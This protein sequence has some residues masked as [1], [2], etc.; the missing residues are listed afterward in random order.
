MWPIG[1]GLV[2]TIT[3]PSCWGTHFLYLS[4]PKSGNL[5]PIIPWIFSYSDLVP[6]HVTWI[7]RFLPE[8][9]SS[10]PGWLVGTTGTPKSAKK[11]VIFKGDKKLTKYCSNQSINWPWRAH[12][13]AHRHRYHFGNL[14]P[15]NC[16]W[17]KENWPKVDIL[18]KT[19]SRNFL[20]ST[21]R[22]LILHTLNI[23]VS[24][25]LG[26]YVVYITLLNGTV[27]L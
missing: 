4:N 1:G 19:F 13:W 8:T 27:I 26:Y 9:P 12:F 14:W 5:L 16:E 6:N 25:S 2:T 15:N 20:L 18:W 21:F 24:N 11:R 17:L 22:I 23:H 10:Y 7:L 3:S